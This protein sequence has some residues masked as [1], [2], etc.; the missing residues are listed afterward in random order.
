MSKQGLKKLVKDWFYS[1]L[2]IEFR[3]KDKKTREVALCTFENNAWY[4]HINDP[5]RGVTVKS[6]RHKGDHREFIVVEC[7]DHMFENLKQYCYQEYT[8]D[9]VLDLIEELSLYYRFLK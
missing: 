6:I 4:E 9:Q 8:M 5:T 2:D 3:L 1:D 7:S